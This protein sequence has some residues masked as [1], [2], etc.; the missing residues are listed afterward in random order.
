MK[1]LF[2]AEAKENKVFPIGAGIWLR[3]HPGDRV[4]YALVE[5]DVTITTISR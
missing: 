4:N 2:L 3:I 5:V 1:E